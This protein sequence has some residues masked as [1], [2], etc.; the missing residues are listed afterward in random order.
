MFYGGEENQG[1]YPNR[2]E[3]VPFNSDV[4]LR[5]PGDFDLNPFLNRFSDGFPVNVFDLPASIAFRSIVPNFRNPLVHKWNFT[6]QR[7]LGS[8][9]TLEVAYIGSKGQHLVH[10]NDPNQPTNAPIAGT[11][12]APRRRFP[13][14]D[15]GIATTHSTGISRYHGLATKLE[16]TFSNGVQFLAAYT[17]SHALTNV[18]TTLSGGPGQRDVTNWT[19]EYSTA[20]FSIKHRFVYSTSVILPFGRGK[21][22]GANMSKLADSLIGNWQVN[23]IITLSTGQPFNLT[24]RN[25]NCACGNTTRPDLVPGKNP[26]DPP[27]GGRTPE[28]WFDTT[29]VTNPAPGTYGTLGNFSNYGPGFNN[30]DFSLFKD[31]RLSERYR[32]QFRW[33]AFNLFNTPH[34]N[35]QTINAEQGND[36]FGR[37]AGTISGTE[38]HMQFALRFQF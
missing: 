25:A 33:E 14:I 12:T 15:A 31:F 11:P 38:R 23:S 13:F 22:F 3:G 37:I 27:P 10:N 5:P 17:W 4:P 20:D 21:K 28:L 7:E 24:T 36:A 6:I 35:V 16:K 18:G 9:T 30:V 1:G 26:N 19:Q 34:F 32:I 2:G 8:N 29:A